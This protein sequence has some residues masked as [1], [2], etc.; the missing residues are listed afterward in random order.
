MPLKACEVLTFFMVYLAE[1][2]LIKKK[3]TNKQTKA[4]GK[5]YSYPHQL[6]LDERHIVIRTECFWCL[7]G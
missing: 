1:I 3:K 4:I 7:G 5:K 6:E 2:K